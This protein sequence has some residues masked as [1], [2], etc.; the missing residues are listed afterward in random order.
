MNTWGTPYPLMPN[1]HC[2]MRASGG[3]R[4]LIHELKLHLDGWLIGSINAGR[5]GHGDGSSGQRWSLRRFI[6]N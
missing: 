5:T 4:I 1:A 2:P 3:K 6:P